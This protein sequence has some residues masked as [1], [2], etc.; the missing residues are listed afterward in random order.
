MPLVQRL[1]LI[2]RGMPARGGSGSPA[3]R[4][5]SMRSA[6]ARARSA[7]T[8]RKALSGAVDGLDAGQ[9]VIGELPGGHLAALQLPAPLGDTHQPCCS[10]SGATLSAR[11][12]VRGSPRRVRSSSCSS[13]PGPSL[14]QIGQKGRQRRLQ[15]AAAH[16]GTEPVGDIAATGFRPGPTRPDPRPLA[17]CAA[18][19]NRGVIGILAKR[20]I[21]PSKDPWLHR[22]MSPGKGEP[23]MGVKPSSIASG[24]A[25]CSSSS[26]ASS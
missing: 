4:A 8:S 13:E 17:S 3:A 21:V 5:A 12:S 9:V 16:K 1:S 10:S 6:S 7:V 11:R 14:L 25:T 20:T 22:R 19:R 26:G 15:A 18:G 24:R 2:A 23:V